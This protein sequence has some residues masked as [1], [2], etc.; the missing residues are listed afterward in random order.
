[1]NW[2]A[3]WF[4]SKYYHILYKNR[5]EEE[6]ILF[7][8]KLINY[9]N[10]KKNIRII[11]I[12]CGKGRHATHLN[13]IGFDVTG[14]DLSKNS[15]SKA[16]NKKKLSFHVH[17]MRKTYRENYFD[18]ATNLFTSFG[19]FKSNKENQNV[20]N[21]MSKNLKKEGLLIIDFINMKHAIKNLTAYEEK[22]INRI[23]FKIKKYIKSNYLIKEIS[24]KEKKEIFKFQEKI[25]ILNLEDFHKMSKIAG[26]KIINIFGNYQFDLFNENTSERLILICKKWT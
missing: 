23:K 26:L 12:A 13:N 16:K 20:M 6:A 22:K 3:N 1:M 15:I 17:D 18:I 25:Q 4:D 19:Y 11:D 5:D 10:P 8:N 7:I 2:F 21:A 9:L 14:I 24:V